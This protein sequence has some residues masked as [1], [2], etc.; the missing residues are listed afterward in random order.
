M[1]FKP[2]IEAIRLPNG[3]CATALPNGVKLVPD[4]L[5]C[6]TPNQARGSV[7]IESLESFAAYVLEH[8]K[9]GTPTIFASP[10]GTYLNA[11]LDWHNGECSLPSWGEHTANYDLKYTPEFNAWSAINGRVL[12]QAIFAE[13]VEEH[14]A[15]I[16]TPS[17]ADVLTVVTTLCGKRKVEFTNVINLANG[18]KSVQ[19]AETTDAKAA[20]DIRVPSEIKIRIPIFVGSEVETTFDIRALFRYR[21]QDGRLGFEVKLLHLDKVTALAFEQILIALRK[22]LG[23][24]EFPI[25]K[26]HVTISPRSVLENHAVKA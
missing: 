25:I 15:D 7:D 21:I 22:A 13:F 16:H 26:G 17:A 8:G 10:S 12:N 24:V 6:S 20:G 23:D 5:F 14:L 1:D 2:L 4:E 18:D 3:N 11:V 9:D 19:W